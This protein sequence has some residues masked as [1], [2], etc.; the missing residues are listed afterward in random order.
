MLAGIFFRK[1][2]PEFVGV[3]NQTAHDPLFAGFNPGK[4]RPRQ[5]QNS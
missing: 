4:K 1:C 3:M 2:T 5:K